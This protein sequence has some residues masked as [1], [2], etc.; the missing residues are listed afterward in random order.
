MLE[1]SR[2]IVIR[3]DDTEI[4]VLSFIISLNYSKIKIGMIRE[5][6]GTLSV[7]AGEFDEPFHHCR[8]Q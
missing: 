7:I 5:C 6:F 2:V 4:V 1:L 3:D 8:R